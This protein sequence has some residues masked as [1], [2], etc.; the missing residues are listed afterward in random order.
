MLN[1]KTTN[2]S[3]HTSDHFALFHHLDH[4]SVEREVRG[5]KTTVCLENEAFLGMNQGFETLWGA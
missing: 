2:R 5:F 1:R 4:I 3:I